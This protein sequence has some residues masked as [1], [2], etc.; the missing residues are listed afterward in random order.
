MLQIEQLIT[1]AEEKTLT[2]LIE[3]AQSCLAAIASHGDYQL[4][5]DSDL[6]VGLDVTLPDAE[7]CLEQLALMNNELSLIDDPS[8]W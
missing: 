1:S 6:L 2:Q 5:A 8:P 7:F 3:E 4:M